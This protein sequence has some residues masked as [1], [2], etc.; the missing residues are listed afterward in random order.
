MSTPLSG[1]KWGSNTITWAFASPSSTG[2]VTSAISDPSQQAAVE[3]GI[4]QWAQVS[5]VNLA[6]VSDPSQANI[7][8][9]YGNL[10][11]LLG[12]SLW[13]YTSGSS[14]YTNA[15]VLLQDPESKPLNG[16]SLTYSGSDATLQQLATHEFGAAIGLAEGS[17][18][19]ANSVMNHMQ[20]AANRVPDGA[21]LAAIQ[22]LYGTGQES[23]AAVGASSSSSS[24]SAMP[25][26]ASSSSATVSPDKLSLVL[27]EDAWNGNAQ[28]IIK[29]NGEQMGATT[30]VSALHD[31][32]ET[33]TFTY[34]GDWSGSAPSVEIDFVNDA[35][36]GSSS[37]DRNLYV[38][39]VSYNGQALLTAP[40][41]LLQSG[42]Y[43]VPSSN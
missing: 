9:G 4:N 14:T 28:F 7:Q 3:A 43:M 18:S 38:D 5:G 32:G 1:L 25:S 22:S 27:S 17:G 39:Q 15:T 26:D 41:E 34:T 6:E 33:Q 21:D 37:T 20:T 30:S 12:E 29:A 36:G 23:T 13:G 11:G 31:Q 24:G 42:P 16:S 40:Q 2:Q 19:D 35:Y 8:V 10:N